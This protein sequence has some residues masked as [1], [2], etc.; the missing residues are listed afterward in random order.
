MIL[1][2]ARQNS[3]SVTKDTTKVMSGISL[4]ERRGFCF[5]LF[6]KNESPYAYAFGT[7][8]LK[9]ENCCTT[10]HLAGLESSSPYLNPKC[11]FLKIPQENTD[12]L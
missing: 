2:R 5:V 3:W 4:N 1:S 9:Q 10:A 12:L 11:S 6:F 8:Y 7:L